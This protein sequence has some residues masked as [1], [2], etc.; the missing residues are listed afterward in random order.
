MNL[1]YSTFL[2]STNND[3]ANGIAVD[4]AGAAYV[5][6][7]TTSTNFPN[8]V[9]NIAALHSFVATNTHVLFGHECFPD[10]DH[11]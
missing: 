9:T 6:G 7:W 2:G 11:Q 1:I 8:T 5:T 10:Q 4:N 3:V